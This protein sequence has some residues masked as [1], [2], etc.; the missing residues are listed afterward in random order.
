MSKQNKLV[1]PVTEGR[2]EIADGKHI[3]TL[4][5]I[6]PKDIV[7]GGKTIPY[8]DLVFT[9]EDEE[10]GVNK[11]VYEED[12]EPQLMTLKIGCSQTISRSSK[13][14]GLLVSLGFSLKTGEKIDLDELI[15]LK[16]SYLTS[17][18]E[19]PYKGEFRTFSEIIPGTVKKL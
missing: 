18:V 10:D 7:S 17:N 12:G 3:G 1:L 15:G 4:I 11:Y 16:V 13:L 8:L 19:K 6:T 9:I 5:E 14:G 2:R